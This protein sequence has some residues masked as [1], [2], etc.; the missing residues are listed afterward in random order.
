MCVLW[1]G[2]DLEFFFGG[3]GLKWGGISV[4]YNARGNRVGLPDSVWDSLGDLGLEPEKDKALSE[5]QCP[6]IHPPEHPSAPSSGGAYDLS[7]CC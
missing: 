4:V 3:E 2:K 7:L 6:R 1:I 5:M